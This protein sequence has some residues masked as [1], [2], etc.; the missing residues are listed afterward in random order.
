MEAPAR[1]PGLF[2]TSLVK[3]QTTV[4]PPETRRTR[5]KAADPGRKDFDR[6]C[7]AAEYQT[8]PIT[9]VEN[10]FRHSG[11]QL[12]RERVKRAML[13][14]MPK[15]SRFERFENCGSDCVVEYSPSRKQHRVKA[16]YCGDRFCVPCC[17]ARA[18]KFQKK[19]ASLLGDETP[20][21]ITLTLRNSREQLSKLIDHLLAS[22]RRLR[23]SAVWK[24]RVRA[25]V[26]VIEIKRGKG[27]FGWHPHLHI[28]ALGSYLPQGELSD[29]WRKSSGGSF[30]VDVQRARKTPD[31]AHYV[32]KYVSKG[33]TA[34]VARDHDSLVECIVAMRGRR[35]LVTFGDW[36]GLDPDSDDPVATDWKRVGTLDYIHA[37]F[38]RGEQWAAGVYRSLGVTPPEISRGTGGDETG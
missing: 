24:S 10:S 19:L 22:F 34:E 29:A 7:R 2:F 1:V 17:R 28:I 12:E 30:I 18:L 3:Q 11:W 38:L 21:F 9:A 15:P 5:Y 33:W 25:G 6:R 26:G 14:T 8:P 32:T 27:G 37:A 31:A 35:L 23:Q 4:D 20:L 16:N 36:Y 13:A